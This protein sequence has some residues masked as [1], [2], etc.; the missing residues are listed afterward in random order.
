MTV[1]PVTSGGF[2]STLV[3]MSAK[4]HQ[5]PTQTQSESTSVSTG[6][7]A[8]GHSNAQQAEAARNAKGTAEGLAN[9]RAALGQWLGPELYK[10]VAPHV[11]LEAVAGYADSALMGTFSALLGE[12]EKLDPA[13][14]E[15]DLAKFEAAL[16]KEFGKT[17]GEWVKENGG[18]LVNGLGEWVD[19]NPELIVMTALLAAAGAYLA[20]ASIPELSTT[21]GIGDDLKVK[22]GA[23][24]GTLQ[25]IAIEQVS[26]ELSLSSAPLVAAMKVQPGDTTKTEF[27]GSYGD[28]Q[29]KLTVDGVVEGSDLT[30]L[31]VQGLM[32]Q[33]NNTVSGGYS[34][35]NGTEKLKVEVTE[36]DGNTSQ[37]TGVDYNTTLG[38]LTLKNTLD[39]SLDGGSARYQSSTS[40]DGNSTQSLSL[41][42]TVNDQ[43]SASLTLSEVAKQLGASDSY[44]LTKEQKASLGVNFDSKDLD[45]S[46]KLSTSSAGQHSAS[47][48]LDTQFGGGFQA[49]GDA[50]SSW[51]TTESLEVGAYFGYRDPKEFKTYMAKYRYTDTG[52]TTHRWDLMVEEKLG[53][54]YTRVQHQ[55]NAGMQGNNWQTTAQGAYF[56]N[57]NVALIGGAQY[58]GNS[59]GQ[60]NLA[61]QLGAQI[62]GVPLVVTHDFETNTTTLGVTFKFGR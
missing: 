57:D 38:I 58:T 60:H 10:A 9:Y 1:E 51:G 21:L 43:L 50:K 39:T 2:V 14:N 13:N 61:P 47:G 30:L 24:L 12:L 31:N 16:K 29:R 49:G 8:S 40:S 28:A 54:I 7:G 3:P 34:Q 41:N 62:H 18:G 23:K 17:A 27:S 5:T 53:P 4:S 19:A 56:L 36:R 33:G 45:A 26:A 20:N 15:A 37:V 44:Q 22:L 32:Q 55:L 46:L 11:T 6:N 52:E 59:S 42:Q 48:S 25:N 35:D